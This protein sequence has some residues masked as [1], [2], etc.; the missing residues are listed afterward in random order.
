MTRPARVVIDLAALEHNF[1][2]VRE[3]APHSKVMAVV[4]AD[5]YGHGISRIARKLAAADAFGVACLEEAR[6]LRS[7]GIQQRIV[8]LEGPYASNELDEIARLDLDIVVH[9]QSQV[10]MLEG[11][12]LPGQVTV[13]LKIDSGMH[14]LGFQ[15]FEFETI[16]QRLLDCTAVAGNIVLMTHLALASDR[17]NDMTE[18]QLDCFTRI[19]KGLDAEKSIAN[20][21]AVLAFADSHA[22]WVRPGLMLYGVSPLSDSLSNDEGLIPVMTLESRLIAVKMLKANDPVGYGATYRC[23]EDM[24][25]GVVAAGYGDGYPRH[26]PSGTPVLVNGKR[27]TLIGRASMDMLTVD[28]R[29]LPEADV[30]D[31]VIL[32]GRGLP[33]EEVANHAGTIAYELLCGVHKRLQFTENG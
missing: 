12:T 15:E 28:L 25:V 8:L 26:A 18:S 30:G 2:R 32:W 11:C 24:R 10:E 6:E 4:K 20:S 22:D 13:W 1:H 19:C 9:H 21:A 7:A 5:A 31:P 23:P 29:E 17:H 27:V 3:L 14:R 16:Y 33:V